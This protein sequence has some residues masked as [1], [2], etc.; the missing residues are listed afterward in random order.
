MLKQLRLGK[1][2]TQLQMANLAKIKQPSYC[3]IE[4]GKRRPSIDIA[5]RIAAVLE[6]EWSKIYENSN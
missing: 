1:N 3:N 6:I 4:N 5:K 2:L